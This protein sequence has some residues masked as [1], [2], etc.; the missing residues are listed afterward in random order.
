MPGKRAAGEA[1]LKL[2]DQ[3][4]AGRRYFVG[5]ALT[6]ADIALFAYTH[7]AGDAGFRLADYPEIAGWIDRVA[8]APGFVPM[9][10]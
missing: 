9:T 8:A 1:A 3:H 2:M 5:D 10:A 4:L 7:V 6:L